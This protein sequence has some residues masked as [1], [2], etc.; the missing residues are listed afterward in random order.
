M[1][2]RLTAASVG[3][4]AAAIFLL[5]APVYSGFDGERPT[6]KTLLQVNGAWVVIPVLFPV[7]V[8]LVPL[9]FRNQA[10]RVIAA[11]VMGAYVL[12][13]GFSIG[14]FYLPGACSSCWRRASATRPRFATCCTEGGR[15]PVLTVRM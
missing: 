11:I 6:H 3:L 10:V 14:L 8:A 9:I 2:T 4:A 13:S 5:V 15:S 1:R 12:V 7:L